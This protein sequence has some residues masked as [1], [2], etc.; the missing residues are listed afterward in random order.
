MS[1]VLYDKEI[2]DSFAS[3]VEV[4]I[5][6]HN[7]NQISKVF[8]LIPSYVE[9]PNFFPKAFVMEK[10][11]VRFLTID[12]LD[13][14]FRIFPFWHKDNCEAFLAEAPPTRRKTI[15]TS[16][17]CST[18]ISFMKPNVHEH[19]E[20]GEKKLKDAKCRIHFHDGKQGKKLLQETIERFKSIDSSVRHNKQAYD[21][22]TYLNYLV[23][24]VPPGRAKIKDSAFLKSV[25]RTA[26]QKPMDEGTVRAALEYCRI[27]IRRITRYNDAYYQN[28]NPSKMAIDQ[29]RESN[30]F[31]N[32]Y[33]NLDGAGLPWYNSRTILW[34]NRTKL[35][36]AV[37]ISNH[38]LESLGKRMIRRYAPQIDVGDGAWQRCNKCGAYYPPTYLETKLS[39]KGVACKHCI[40]V[41][42]KWNGERW[43]DTYVNR[44][45][46][47]FSML[48]RYS[49]DVTETLSFY[50]APHED[51]RKKLPYLGIE[52]ETELTRDL[53]QA[54]LIDLINNV[55]SDLDGF[56]I[57]KSDGSLDYGAEIV[58]APATFDYHK[59]YNESKPSPWK[60]FF[61]NSSKNLYSYFTETCGIHVH[62]SR[63]AFKREALARLM[64]FINAKKHN[65]FIEYVS[66]RATN[67]WAAVQ[68]YETV[69]RA[70]DYVGH[71]T[72]KY[73]R[74]HLTSRNTAEFRIFKG[75]TSE[76]GV[77]KALEFVQACYEFVHECSN[78]DVNPTAFCQ[79]LMQTDERKS[80]FENLVTHLRKGHYV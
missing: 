54:T 71:S 34:L 66:E 19:F 61:A 38:H 10:S 68:P 67:R 76:F 32:K 56:A 51:A 24:T 8:P 77:F 7:I 48:G 40:A 5:G 35:Q 9:L 59:G 58:S 25:T 27:S 37:P 60:K 50:C 14:L 11:G 78:T 46:D 63:N 21:A 18:L 1:T 16:I 49:A 55:K 41:H 80:R 65:K 64:V 39:H 42:Y 26:A 75:N 6:Q 53:S 2:V 13:V 33:I 36:T 79:W 57:L 29:I 73:V 17:I 12:S 23:T 69:E 74:L 15:V 47:L 3:T 4:V 72:E 52:I 45:R 31:N 22:F 44:E 20:P 30:V 70:M 43:E 62:I 28:I